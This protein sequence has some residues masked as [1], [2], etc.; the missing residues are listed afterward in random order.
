MAKVRGK[1]KKRRF[2]GTVSRN[3]AKQ[4]RGTQFAHLNLPKGVNIFKEEPGT[5]VSLDIMPYEVTDVNHPDRDEEYGIAVPGEL[6]YKRPYW[7]HRNIGANNESVV[8]PSSAKQKCPICEHRAQLLKDGVDW[9]DDSVKALKPSMRNLYIVIPKGNKNY[10]EKPHIWD[11]SQF[12]F[13]DKLNEEIQEDEE[14]ETFPDLEEGYTLRIRFSE[15]QIGSN[16][17]A[18]TSRIDFVQRKKQYKES[19]LKDIPALDEILTIPTYKAI[20][21]L[22][23]GGLSHDELDDDIEI[24]EE[25]APFDNDEMEEENDDMEMEE[26]NEDA[27]YDTDEDEDEDELDDDGD[28]EDNDDAGDDDE[29]EEP[30]PEPKKKP[31]RKKAA[32]KGKKDKPA[33]KKTKG[34]SGKKKNRC[35]HGHTF[36]EDCESFDECDECDEW[37]AC[38]DASDEG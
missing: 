5:R 30:E 18:D 31:T 14:F 28:E 2:K 8:C 27:D 29:E 35:P 21:A 34:K 10:D 19:I 16:K 1:S 12:L 20:E 25:D 33:T 26:E 24:A 37:E 4:A 15:E 32:P 3:I 13:Q 11:V 17:F 22:F 23:F 6:W 36:G 7:L 38:M 9:S